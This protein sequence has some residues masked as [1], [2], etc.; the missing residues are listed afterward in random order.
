MSSRSF[1]HVSVMFSKRTPLS[2]K[3]FN[4]MKLTYLGSAVSWI[5][6]MECKLPCSNKHF[7]RTLLIYL[8][9][10]HAVRISAS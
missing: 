4:E 7:G 8:S 10:F 1:L 5:P 3:N 9:L 2:P 6:S